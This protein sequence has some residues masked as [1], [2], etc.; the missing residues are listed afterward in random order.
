MTRYLFVAALFLAA[1]P[2]PGPGPTPI[3]GLVECGTDAIQAC[4]SS[5]LPGVNE[6]L[7]GK[8]DVV[9]CILGLIQPA[10]CITYE[11]VACLTQHE[12]SAAEH[13][14]QTNPA[15]TRDARRAA[16]A[17]EFLEK[18]GARFR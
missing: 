9:T 18:T 2:K 17:R 11:V 14:A 7:S 12:G 6:C 3:P 15:N 13:A 16:R 10:G 5:A 1:C 4:A 8:G